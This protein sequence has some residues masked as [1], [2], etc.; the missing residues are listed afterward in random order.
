MIAT[1]PRVVFVAAIER[2]IAAMSPEGQDRFGSAL[3][4]RAQTALRSAAGLSFAGESDV[5]PMAAIGASRNDFQDAD[6]LADFGRFTNMFD[7][8]IDSRL[9]RPCHVVRIED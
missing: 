8:Y 1:I 9:A 7:M 2:G 6:F 3:R 4:V 5:C